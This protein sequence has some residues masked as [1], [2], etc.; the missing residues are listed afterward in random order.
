MFALKGA[1][2]SFFGWLMLLGS[3]DLNALPSASYTP[4][5]SIIS[6][7][8][9]QQIPL[10]FD[11]FL[12]VNSSFT[13]ETPVAKTFTQTNKIFQSVT[14]PLF[15]ELSY[16][17]IGQQIVVNLSVKTIIFPFHCFT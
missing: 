2:L 3:S 1:I 11:A 7:D 16:Y 13:Y 10:V 9:K 8:N 14:A 6:S 12:D 4:V 5:D 17:T 15:Y